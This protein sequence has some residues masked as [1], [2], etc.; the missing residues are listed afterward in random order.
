VRDPAFTPRFDTSGLRT[1]AVR[2][3]LPEA[4][5]DAVERLRRAGYGRSDADVVRAAL[6]RWYLR[7]AGAGTR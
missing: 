6:M 7:G 1:R 3:V 4:A 5:R 2:I